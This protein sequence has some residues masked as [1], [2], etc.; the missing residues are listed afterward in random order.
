[1]RSARSNPRGESALDVSQSDVQLTLAI[2]GVMRRFTN[3][4]VQAFVRLNPRANVRDFSREFLSGIVLESKGTHYQAYQ[5]VD[6]ETT[7]SSEDSRPTAS[8]G[9]TET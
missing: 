4:R 5:A 8:P 9:F 6:R 3:Q 1:M 2:L 7:E